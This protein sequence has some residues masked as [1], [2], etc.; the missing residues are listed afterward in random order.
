MP[1]DRSPQTFENNAQPDGTACLAHVRGS[2]LVLDALLAHK[3]AACLPTLVEAFLA[4]ANET[5]EGCWY[6][7]QGQTTKAQG[8]DLVSVTLYFSVVSEADGNAENGKGATAS[9]SAEYAAIW[10]KYC[11]I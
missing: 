5:K 9:G 8:P 7:F 2:V 1:N 3:G 11:S 10:D 4:A 6:A